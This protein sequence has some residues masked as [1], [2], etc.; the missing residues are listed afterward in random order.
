MKRLAPWLVLL[1]VL[2]ACPLWGQQEPPLIPLADA[3]SL[4]NVDR[5]QRVD[6]AFKT[7][8]I[9]LRYPVY[10]QESNEIN[11]Y[12][13]GTKIVVYTGLLDFA[14][15]EGEVAY[16]LGHELAHN[17]GG[18]VTKQYG[19]IL[20]M[21]VVNTALSGDY[22]YQPGHQRDV[23]A[24]EIVQ[25]ATLAMLV[26]SYGRTHEY[27]ADRQGI[28][29]MVRAGYD[30]HDAVRFQDKLLKKYGSGDALG[31]I[32]STHPP[33]EKRSEQIR[34]I[35]EDE[36]EQDASGRW[37]RK[38]VI[39]TRPSASSGQQRLRRGTRMAVWTGGV[40]LL[41]GSIEQFGFEGQGWVNRRQ[42]DHNILVATRNGAIMGFLSGYLLVVDVPGSP[43][44]QFKPGA[45]REQP[46][47]TAG[48]DPAT[49]RW[50]VQASVRF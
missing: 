39:P 37:H 21:V 47:V 22:R 31:G 36:F 17:V 14:D 42:R 16:V 50:Q 5:L 20:G 40:S 19:V 18:H 24:T 10:V 44:P 43:P 49:Q 1:L 6:E 29:A 9:P 32:F 25:D 48:F 23:E 13:D 30:P 7:G 27:D 26:T 35:V 38:G 12:A 46:V 45:G 4:A 8:G 28:Y 33:S 3:G 15:S 41:V 11:A 34:H 2:G